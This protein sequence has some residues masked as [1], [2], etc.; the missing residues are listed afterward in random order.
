MIGLAGLGYGVYK[1]IQSRRAN[2]DLT[3]SDVSSRRVLSRRGGT[4]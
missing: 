3:D 1:F 4:V 2:S